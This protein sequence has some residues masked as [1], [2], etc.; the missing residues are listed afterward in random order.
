MKISP[1]KA[2]IFSTT[3]MPAEKIKMTWLMHNVIADLNG[4]HF[5][6]FYALAIA[7]II[8]A[9]YVSVRSMV[10]QQ[11]KAHAVATQD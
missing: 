9:S 8:L 4:P 2:K 11:T 10:M 6:A 3:R 1:W 7:A 5:L